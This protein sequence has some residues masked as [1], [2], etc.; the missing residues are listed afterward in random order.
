MISHALYLNFI[1]QTLS[2][3]A[4]TKLNLLSYKV[5]RFFNLTVCTV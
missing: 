4:D 1:F 3:P 5:L 2:L